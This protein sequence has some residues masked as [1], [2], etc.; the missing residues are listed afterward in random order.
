M[1]RPNRNGIEEFDLLALA[2]GLLDKDPSRK[3]LIEAF[4]RFSPEDDARVRDYRRQTE[5]LRQ[6]YEGRIHDPVPEGLYAALDTRRAPWFRRPLA[7]LAAAILLVAISGSSGWL[8][9]RLDRTPYGSDQD[10]LEQTYAGY[11]DATP[12]GAARTIGQTGV[13][14]SDR[15]NW[16]LGSLSLTLQPPRLERLGYFLAGTQMIAAGGG[17]IAR[18]DYAADDGRRF[19][20]FLKTKT[21]DEGSHPH[22]SR[23]DGVSLVHWLDGPV[24]V[25][26]AS[27]LPPE[28]ALNL[29]AEVRRALHDS[30]VPGPEAAGPLPGD[31]L[32]GT[33][34]MPG[35]PQL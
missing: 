26:V 19:S 22:L 32:L 21:E 12:N 30:A 6:R 33:G 20:L 1:D 8:I 31:G 5:A 34:S 16:R 13:V 27:H 18:L 29:G 9:G 7:R 15:P 11:V 28:Q 3:A 4:L 2:D 10:F 14:H 35:K 23:R 17:D 24:A 25:A